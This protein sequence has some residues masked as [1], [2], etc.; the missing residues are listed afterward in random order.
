M[1]RVLELQLSSSVA[2]AAAANASA[3]KTRLGYAKASDVGSTTFNSIN[4]NPT[5]TLVR[6]TYLGDANLS[7][8][9]DTTDFNALAGHFNQSSQTWLNGDFNYD[10][11]VNAL[12]FN[13]L[14][15]N[16]GATPIA[17]PALGTLVPEPATMGLMAMSGLLLVRR[18]R[19]GLG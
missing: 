7:G 1:I 6:Y 18:R 3:K 5:D 12:D 10:G 4:V 15:S 2:A 13:A 17:T 19:G 11:T 9:V 16:F 8:S 14:A